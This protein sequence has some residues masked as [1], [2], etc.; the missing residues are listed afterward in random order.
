MS[1]YSVRPRPGAPVA[2]PLRWEELDETLAPRDLTMD[3]VIDRVEREGDLH[4]P[5]LSSGQRLESAL[6]TVAR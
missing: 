1:A 2:A 5:L 6:A 3:V 4:A